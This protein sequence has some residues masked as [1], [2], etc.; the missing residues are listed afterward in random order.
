MGRLLSSNILSQTL[1][2]YNSLLYD[3]HDLH[4]MNQ[5]LV[6][7]GVFSKYPSEDNLPL[8]LFCQFLDVSINTLVL[9]NKLRV[10]LGHGVDEEAAGLAE[11]RHG[12][13]TGGKQGL[14]MGF[15]RVAL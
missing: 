4:C 2:I 3:L 1:T 5:T 12:E 7:L 9:L 14:V 15:H 8:S 11:A 13:E 6:I 10:L